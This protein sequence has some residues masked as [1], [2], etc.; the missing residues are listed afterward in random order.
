MPKDA[1]SRE[2]VDCRKRP[3]RAR[4]YARH[5]LLNPVFRHPQIRTCSPEIQIQKLLPKF[6]KICDHIRSMH[7]TSMTMLFGE[8]W[9][10]LAPIT[11]W[12][13]QSKGAVCRGV[14]DFDEHHL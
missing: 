3:R 1:H 5:I 7:E 6:N 4:E 2:D 8:T 12:G 13:V 9:T 11:L 10:I 14:G